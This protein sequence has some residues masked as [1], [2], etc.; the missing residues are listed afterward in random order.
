LKTS[1]TQRTLA[2]YRKRGYLCAIV[3]KWSQYPP[4]GH[5]VDLFGFIDV[6]ALGRARTIAIQACAGSSASARIAKI[7]ADPRLPKILE[8]GWMVVVVAWRKAGARGKRKLWDAREVEVLA[9]GVIEGPS[10]LGVPVA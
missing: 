5:R 6:L 4:P 8:A 7:H 2:L 10:I 3:E 1:P 9:D